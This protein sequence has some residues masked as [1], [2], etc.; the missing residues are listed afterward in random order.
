M[1]T[2]SPGVTRGILPGLA[3]GRLL[4]PLLDLLLP[5]RCAGC[6]DTAGPLCVDCAAGLAGRP[7]PHRPCPAPA[8]LPECWTA[9]AYAGAARRLILAY[10]ERGRTA[11]AP[12]LAACL[13]AVTAAAVPYRTG[14]VVLVPVPSARAAR[15]ARGHDPVGRLAA[16]TA[17]RLA[18]PDRPVVVAPVL[19]QRRRVADQAGLDAARRAANLHRAF[20]VVRP[21]P[22]GACVLV[23]DVITTGATLA[24]AARA[25]REAGVRPSLAVTIAAT[26]RRKIIRDDHSA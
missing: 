8:G 11:L 13:A 22:P 14:P 5:Q 19:G 16:L 26:R 7:G 21:V 25:L 6:G 23:D 15:R 24:E 4:G 9:T 17:R 18:R 20:A 10:K 3:P 1:R 2:V 12:A